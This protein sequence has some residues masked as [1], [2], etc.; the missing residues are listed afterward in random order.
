MSISPLTGVGPTPSLTNYESS[1]VSPDSYVQEQQKM[2]MSDS[3][4]AQ[5]QAIS[6]LDQ[7]MSDLSYE[8]VGNIINTTA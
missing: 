8:Q 4:L 7:H 1:T 5:S 2:S 3:A 6:N